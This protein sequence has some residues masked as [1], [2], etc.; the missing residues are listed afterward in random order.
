LFRKYDNFKKYDYNILRDGTLGYAAFMK[1]I[2]DGIIN[3]L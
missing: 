1:G 2:D 3:V